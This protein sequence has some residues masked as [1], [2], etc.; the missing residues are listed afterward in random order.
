MIIHDVAGIG[1]RAVAQDHCR[2]GSGV[3]RGN[4]HDLG[5]GFRAG[6]AAGGAEGR[7]F[8]FAGSQS[9]RITGTAGVAAGTAV[10]A[11]QD[12]F[13]GDRFF[14]DRNGHD[15]GRDG[16]KQSEYQAKDGDDDDR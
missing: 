12:F 5:N 13:D 16:Q 7:I 10:R 14:I 15:D 4:A 8:T 3:S 1:F 9:S 11:R 2:H 6:G